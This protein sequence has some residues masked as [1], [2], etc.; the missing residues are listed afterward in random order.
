MICTHTYIYIAHTHVY[1]YNDVWISAS[2]PSPSTLFRIFS[3][4]TS[5]DFISIF[6]ICSNFGCHLLVS[7]AKRWKRKKKHGKGAEHVSRDVRLCRMWSQLYLGSWFCTVATLKPTSSRP[8]SDTCH[9]GMC[10]IS[11]PVLLTL[12]TLTNKDAEIWER[13]WN[14]WQLTDE[15]K[16]WGNRMAKNR[17]AKKHR[18]S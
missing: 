3:S 1:I 16:N 13:N 10:S 7:W 6:H 8:S 4:S 12:G 11:N 17:E 18:I 15:H 5:V 14:I 9:G 2:A